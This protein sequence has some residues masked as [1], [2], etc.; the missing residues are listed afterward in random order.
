MT[1]MPVA[2]G[3][4]E[5][6]IAAAHRLTGFLVGEANGT[7]HEA[8]IRDSAEKAGGTQ[9]IDEEKC[10]FLLV[11]PGSTVRALVIAALPER[12]GN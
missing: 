2:G 1:V 11:A 6:C 9:G 8:Q 5:T 3:P 10:A 12:N 7:R 4:S